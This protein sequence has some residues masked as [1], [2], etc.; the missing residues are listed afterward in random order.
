MR[1]KPEAHG[2]LVKVTR[3]VLR[4]RY[5]Q[6]HDKIDHDAY[7]QG[8]NCLE[9][10]GNPGGSTRVLFPLDH[11]KFPLTLTEAAN[12]HESKLMERP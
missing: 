10:V 8:L 6:L 4:L 12:W 7:H 9:N 3:K 2:T 11:R 5:E 1:C